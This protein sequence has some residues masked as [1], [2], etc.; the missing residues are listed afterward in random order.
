MRD[1]RGVPLDEIHKHLSVNTCSRIPTA[2]PGTAKASQKNHLTVLQRCMVLNAV[3]SDEWDTMPLTSGLMKLGETSLWCLPGENDEQWQ[4][5]FPGDP[6][7]SGQ[8]RV[9]GWGT[10]CIS[11]VRIS[12]L[13]RV[14]SRH[15]GGRNKISS[16]ARWAG[17]P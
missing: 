1:S 12:G 8:H 5:A 16:R 6:V 13:Q 7:V 15:Y 10:P 14:R 9:P 11:S 3:E 17:S 2:G 4:R